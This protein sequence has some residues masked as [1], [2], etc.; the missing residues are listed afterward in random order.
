MV[1]NSI[2]KMKNGKMQICLSDGTDFVLY[3]KEVKHYKL[4]VDEDCSP[5]VLDL[6]FCEVLIPRCKKRGLHLLEKQDRT[7]ANLREK[8]IEGLYPK[9]VIDEAIRY[10]AS[11]GYIDDERIARSYINFYQNSRSKSRIRQDLIKKG[12]SISTIDKCLEEEYE[13]DE[14]SLAMSVLKKKYGNISE[15]S[16]EQKAK[17]YRFLAGR[18]FSSEVIRHAIDL[19]DD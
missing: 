14:I 16:Y 9:V 6:I 4:E 10:I 2:E 17:I 5:E 11:F 7:E 1:V 12:C 3:E 13:E 18:G 8:L 15:Y 19:A